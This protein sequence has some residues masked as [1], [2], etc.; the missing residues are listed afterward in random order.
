MW[1]KS[2]AAKIFRLCQGKTH[3]NTH[4]VRPVKLPAHLAVPRGY[5]SRCTMRDQHNR[6]PAAQHFMSVGK[7]VPACISCLHQ[8]VHQV[9][10]GLYHILQ[11]SMQIQLGEKVIIHIYSDACR[12]MQY[13]HQSRAYI[14]I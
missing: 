8:D 6:F 11:L 4:K 13:R 7:H 5:I 10:V 14:K 2:A 9:P 12:Y 3:E 1:C